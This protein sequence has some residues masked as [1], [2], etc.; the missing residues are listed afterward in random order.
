M[1]PMP[2]YTFREKIDLVDAVFPFYNRTLGTL[3]ILAVDGHPRASSTA[4]TLGLSYLA[5]RILDDVL[6]DLLTIEAHLKTP[7]P[8]ICQRIPAPAKFTY[9]H[10]F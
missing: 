6:V 1:M 8:R 7:C 5:L 10:S 4:R 3:M 9:H 2:Y